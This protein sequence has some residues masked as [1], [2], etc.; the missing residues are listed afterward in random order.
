MLLVFS[1]FF[2]VWCE[3]NIQKIKI[4]NKKVECDSNMKLWKNKTYNFSVCIPNNWWELSEYSWNTYS[5]LRILDNVFS[6]WDGIDN[7]INLEWIS[8]N[9]LSKNDKK[10]S[11]WE[12]YII[13]HYDDE[14]KN[15]S[16]NYYLKIW[17][18]KYFRFSFDKKTEEMK[19][20]INSIKVLKEF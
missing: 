2:L 4:D 17:K 14:Q 20:I 5:N 1:I 16:F 7:E 18:D 9:I 3:R 13:E 15:I 12:K 10:Y 11:F 6:I 19:D 8:K